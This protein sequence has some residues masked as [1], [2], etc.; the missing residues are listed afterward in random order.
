MYTFVSGCRIFF[1]HNLKY[2]F[3]LKDQF[4][5]RSM[6]WMHINIQNIQYDIMMR[7]NMDMFEFYVKVKVI[8]RREINIMI[9]EYHVTSSYT[10]YQVGVDDFH[11]VPHTWC[12]YKTFEAIKKKI[13]RRFEYFMS[14]S[15]GQKITF[16][17]TFSFSFFT[18]SINL[19]KIQFRWF[20]VGASKPLVSALF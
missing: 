1:V 3:F 9:F 20:E 2:M 13:F 12:T 4:V 18:T 17:K 11:H 16:V 15:W 19:F 14:G 7:S 5:N 6:I 8:K 10:V